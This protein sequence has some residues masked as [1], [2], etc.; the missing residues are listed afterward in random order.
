MFRKFSGSFKFLRFPL[1][2]FLVVTTVCAAQLTPATPPLADP[3]DNRFEGVK[4]DWTTPAL[5]TS[6]LRAVQPLSSGANDRGSYTVEI[7]RVQWRWADPIDLYIAKPK[8]ITKPPVVLFLYGHKS[9][10]D[11]FLDQNFGEGATSGGFAAVGFVSALTGQRYHDRPF[12]QWFVSELQESLAVSAHDV[13]MV[14]NYLATR[15]DLDMGHVG[16]FA[17]DSGASI[18]ILASAVDPRIQALDLVGPWGD[19][20]DWLKSSPAIPEEERANYLKPE[21]LQKVSGLD[22]VTWLPKVQAKELRL[23]EAMFAP[24]TPTAAKDKLKAAAP[25]RATVVIYKTPEE[26]QAIMDGNRVLDW[27]KGELHPQIKAETNQKLS[28]QSNAAK[29]PLNSK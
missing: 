20:P 24:T 27:I 2:A 11:R 13:Q 18:A 10:T 15:S 22:P 6:T 25:P 23:Q 29:S 19:W 14:L 9:D 7:V 21:F 3:T 17:Q 1:L 5:G 8:G 4:E 26:T 16:M 12:K 28:S